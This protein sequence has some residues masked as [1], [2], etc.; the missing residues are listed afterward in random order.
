MK[1]KN[2]NVIETSRL[3]LICCDKQIMETLFEG[4]EQIAKLLQIHI[5][6]KWSEFGEAPLRWIYNKILEGV[7]PEWLMYLPI[8]K[9]ENGLVGNCGYKGVPKDGMVEIGYEVIEKY[10]CQGL[11]TEIATALIKHA[12]T[13]GQI[14]LIQAHTLAKENE[15]GSVLKKCGMRK[16]EETDDPEDGKIWRWEIRK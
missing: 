12:F 6:G 3:T 9:Q 16:M 4:D 5:S 11:A 15:S 2:R 7:A 10:R 1:T 13:Y 14:H 8:L